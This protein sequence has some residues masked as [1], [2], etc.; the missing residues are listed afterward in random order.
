MINKPRGTEDIFGDKFEKYKY[1]K[2][3]MFDIG[4]RYGFTGIVTPVFESA[5]LFER[6]VGQETDIV[7]KEMYIFK[8]K[9]DREM[10]LRPETTAGIIRAYL[11]EGIF[12]LGAPTKLM[13]FLPVYRYENVQK[14]RQREFNQFAAE[15]LQSPNPIAD[16]EIIKL[17][18]QI[19]MELGIAREDY[20]LKINSIG[21]EL[22]R[23]EYKA[24]LKEYVEKNINDY[25]PDCK[26]RKDTNLLRVLDCKIE[27]CK[28]LNKEAPNILDYL[29]DDCK[30]HF[31]QLII[32][33]ED[34]EIEYEIDNTIVRGLDYYNRTVLEVHDKEGQ[35]LFGGGRYDRLAE[36][37]G[38]RETPAV[39]IGFGIE[40][41]MELV[42]IPENRKRRVDF[43]IV[44][45]MSD[46]NKR[47]T[48]TL[49]RLLRQKGHSVEIDLLDRSFNAQ[50]KHANKLRTK[51]ALIL[52]ED[53]VEND[54]ITVKNMDDGE[55]SKVDFLTFVETII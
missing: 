51:V 5:E 44:S 39:G 32:Y 34:D 10:A 26:R 19:L 20:T 38:G 22:C 9:S 6:S 52:G 30:D 47:R 14:G 43:Y 18:M 42:S 15:L 31:D 33:L 49:A 46:E 55:E 24:K 45:D 35:A 27:K 3:T 23:T 54:E 53:E 13:C 11:E 17:G 48:N 28:E 7:Q 12:N 16:F 4:T 2:D 40:R 25:C 37:L 1:I 36:T 29:C 41:L 8:D 21:C 50:M